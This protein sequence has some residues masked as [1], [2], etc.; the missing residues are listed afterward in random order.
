VLRGETGALAGNSL[1]YRRLSLAWQIIQS[2]GA[3]TVR[4]DYQEFVKL[5]LVY[6]C[7]GNHGEMTFQ[8]PCAL[9][10]A[11]W[12]ANLLYSLKIALLQKDIRNSHYS[13][14]GVK[15]PGIRHVCYTRLQHLVADMQKHSGCTME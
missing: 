13:P 7:D 14:T 5:S 2:C 1:T 11:R 4:E 10:K 6:L 9:H 12:M 3:C 8:R 15:D